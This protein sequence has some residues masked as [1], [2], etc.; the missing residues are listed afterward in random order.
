MLT[1]NNFSKEPTGTP[2]ATTTLFDQSARRSL[3]ALLHEIA[4]IRLEGE[5]VS[6]QP[7]KSFG[8]FN[9]EIAAALEHR[10]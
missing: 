7:P 3:W 6:W 4:G 1:C 8:D 10:Q 9:Q 2:A 5:P